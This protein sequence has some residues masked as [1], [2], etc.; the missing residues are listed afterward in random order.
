MSLIQNIGVYFF[1]DNVN[2]PDN[3]CDAQ[4]EISPLHFLRPI[5]QVAAPRSGPT[6]ST[7]GK[8]TRQQNENRI[9]KFGKSG[10]LTFV[11]EDL[12]YRDLR[13]GTV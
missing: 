11:T 12:W 2:N 4:E 10:S 5:Y 7:L 1:G 8:D 9:R 13:G 3:L 6:L